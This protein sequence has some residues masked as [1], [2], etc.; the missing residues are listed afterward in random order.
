HWLGNEHLHAELAPDLVISFGKSVI[1][2]SLKQFLRKS[3]A[4]HWHIQPDGQSRDTFQHLT[5]ILP[6]STIEF[7]GWLGENLA[8]QDAQYFGRWDDLEKRVQESLSSA[9][10]SLEFGEYPALHFLLG[11]IQI[12]RA[13]CREIGWKSVVD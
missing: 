13:S 4:S 8:P 2:K 1:S 3:G 10:S 9:F 12:G 11:K 5:R 7:L 6:C